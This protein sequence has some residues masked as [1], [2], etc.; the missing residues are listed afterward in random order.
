MAP[1]PLP[2][3]LLSWAA[4]RAG[5]AAQLEVMS[6]VCEHPQSKAPPGCVERDLAMRIVLQSTMVACVWSGVAYG[7]VWC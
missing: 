7:G 5:E 3:T 6:L 1:R 4:S 2:P